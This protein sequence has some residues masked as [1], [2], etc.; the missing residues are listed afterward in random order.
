MEGIVSRDKNILSM[1]GIVS[2]D[3]IS[4]IPR[5]IKIYIS[6]SYDCP[7]STNY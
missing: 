6:E 4:F 2:R 1:E 7:A 5:G 3:T